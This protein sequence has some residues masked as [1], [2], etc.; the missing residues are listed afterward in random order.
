MKSKLTKE[1]DLALN[2]WTG[3]KDLVATILRGPKKDVFE[4]SETLAAI[5][6]YHTQSNKSA[7]ENFSF[8]ANC[9]LSG[10]RHP[11]AS[12]ECRMTKIDGLLSFATLYADEVYIQDPFEDV[13][14]KRKN[15]LNE[16]DRHE[17]LNGIF[18]YMR[19]RPLVE[20]GLIKYAFNTESFCNRHLE[21]IAEPLWERIRKN[22]AQLDSVI[23]SELI[24]CC[25]VTFNN[26]N[27][28]S[29][30]FHIVGPEGIIEHGSVY[31]HPYQPMPKIFGQFTKK[32]PVHRLSRAEIEDSGVLGFVVN[33]IVRDLGRQEWHTALNG[34]SYLCDNENHVRLASKIN[35]KA[36]VASSTAFRKGF[37]HN[38]PSVISND[39]EALLNLRDREEDAFL[40]YRDKIRKLLQKNEAWDEKEVAKVF[41]DEIRPEI[42]LINKKIADWKSN[43]RQSIGEKILFG[44]GAVSLGL[45]AGIL[46][47]DIGQIVAAIGGG[48]AIAGA[49]MD[50]NKTFKEKQQA[51]SNDF[52]FLWQAT[53]L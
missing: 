25:K 35:P 11:C 32:G 24:E 51:R 28:N 47:S 46:P 38:L 14:L 30:F 37:Q 41:R 44:A 20:R 34:T 19:L 12:P 13:A 15:D 21:S 26:E 23:R 40:V 10:G 39:V 49:L 31:F 33:P 6:R 17:I 4:L 52:Y 48:S 50:F 36:F 22:E 45:Y 3:Q 43:T 2:L 16:A 1:F 9:S 7:S 5:S 53:T 8:T 27:V 18:T 29:P 42:N